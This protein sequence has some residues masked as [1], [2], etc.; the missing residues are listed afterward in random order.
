MGCSALRLRGLRI[1]IPLF[2]GRDLAEL[3]WV[4]EDRAFQSQN[5]DHSTGTFSSYILNPKPKTLSPKPSTD[6]PKPLR[7]VGGG[8]GGGAGGCG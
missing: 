5:A 4:M 1:T 6:T 7:G 3:A 2:V 8:V